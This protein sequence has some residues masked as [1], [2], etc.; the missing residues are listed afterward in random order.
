MPAAGEPASE[1]GISLSAIE[2]QRAIAIISETVEKLTFLGSI[3]PDVLQHRDELSKFVGDEISRII[4]EQRQ[5]EARYEQL[6][7]ERGALKGLANKSKY[8][9]VQ[10]EIQDVSRALR[11]STKNLCRNL[12]DN[13]NIQG[14]LMKI[15]RERTDLIEILNMSIRELQESGTCETLVRKVYE[16]KAQQDRENDIIERERAMSAA[17]KQ[18]DEDLSNEK[19][20]HQESIAAHKGQ[21]A[22]LKE[23]LQKIK[24]TTAVDAKY[25]R[26]HETGRT[27]AIVRSYTQAQRAQ[28]NK[29]KELERNLEMEKVVHEE[30]MEFLK[31]KFGTLTTDIEYWGKKH[32]TDFGALQ[33]EYEELKAKQMM[34]R[35][36]LDYLQGRKAEMDEK[37]RQE[38][39]L[40][41]TRIEMEAAAAAEERVRSEACSKIQRIARAYLKRKAAA[42]S[43]KGKK[44]KGG[45]KKGKKKK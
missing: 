23:Q 13:P 32:E 33:A 42:S 22:V 35:E 30:T 36:R 29:I 34:N 31:R 21:I 18:L 8:K 4:Y 39:E 25:T 16:S 26:K 5:L 19:K 27:N 3:T 2:A 24:S 45:G 28:E 40:E 44:K 7:A 14:N 1:E 9:E 41:K 20:Q 15:Q 12:K 11:E 37:E 6:I 43:G 10:S 17:V 38:R